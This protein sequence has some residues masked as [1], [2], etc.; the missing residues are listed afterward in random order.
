VS[1][2]PKPQDH[3]ELGASNAAR[4]M[5]CPGSVQLSRGMP[6]YE[7]EYSRIGT[8]AHAVGA[9]ALERGVDADMWQGL[10]V[11]GIE[12]TEEIV[13]GVGIYVNYCREIINRVG[14]GNYWIEKKL[15]LESL[16]PPGKMFGTGDFTGYD[17]ET[18]T[19][20]VVDYKNGAGVVVEIE[21]N[22][23]TRY[24]GLGAALTLA[25]GREIDQV[26]MTIIQPNAPHADGVIRTETIDAIELMNFAADLL[27]AARKT[28]DPDAPLVPGKHCRFCPASAVCPAQRKQVQALAQVAFEAMPLDVPPAPETLPPDMF[29]DILQKLPILE[30]WATAMRAHA[31]RELEAG[32][33][34]PGFKLVP[35]RPTRKWASETE[36]A[37]VIANELMVEDDEM[38]NRKLKSPAQIEKIVGKKN[39]PADLVVK[40]SSGY[41]LAPDSDKR[42]AVQ[43]H[44]GDAFLALPPA[45]K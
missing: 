11:E 10:E 22:V 36:A 3:A 29:A 35:R 45:S 25:K 15:S 26:K 38:Y 13:E 41:T 27:A 30:D 34:V 8:A 4:W 39:L 21:G 2:A 32:R 31:L 23:Q 16:N 12:I 6:N 28:L 14:K 24:Y 1:Q 40:E 42:P 17:T 19:L 37:A 18:K 43:L 9:M 5:A 7:S 20:E 44:A 33:E